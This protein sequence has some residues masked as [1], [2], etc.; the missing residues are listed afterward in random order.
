MV[1]CVCVCVCVCKWGVACM[2]LCVIL[3]LCEMF[4]WCLFAR[5]WGM[6]YSCVSVCV[7]VGLLSFVFVCD[8]VFV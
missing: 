3:V 6:V 4:G 7:N 2:C 5:G 1:V 8:V